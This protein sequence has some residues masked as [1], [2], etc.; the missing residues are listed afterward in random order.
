P[1]VGLGRAGDGEGVAPVVAEAG[2]GSD[3][4]SGL[5]VLIERIDDIDVVPLGVAGV[6]DLEVV[7][8]GG[9]GVEQ[10]RGGGVIA[11]AP[12]MQT[13]ER[14]GVGG[15]ESGGSAAGEGCERPA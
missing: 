2:D 15:E 4:V 13:N 9:G 8:A 5:E 3:V 10:R 14:V 7:A 11:V 1:V 6:D 12:E